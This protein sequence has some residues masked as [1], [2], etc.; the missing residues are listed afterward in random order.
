MSRDI[1]K[2]TS[3]MKVSN[4]ILVLSVHIYKGS[5]DYLLITHKK[6]GAQICCSRLSSSLTSR[7]S[8]LDSDRNDRQ[9]TNTMLHG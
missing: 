6:T 1:I 7:C 4:E 3:D 8:F 9:Y 5:S 2:N